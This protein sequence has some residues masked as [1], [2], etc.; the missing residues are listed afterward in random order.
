[1]C[2][3]AGFSDLT[4]SLLPESAL[5]GALARRMGQ[6]LLHRG[7]N[8]F[9][10]H[11]SAQSAMAH[12]R[13]AIM[14]PLHG[15]QP[16]TLPTDD[17]DV[18]LIYNGEIYNAPEL[19]RMLQSLG[20][21]FQTHCDTEVLLQC[22]LHFGIECGRMLNGI[23]AFV[24]D[25]TRKKQVFLCRDRFGVKPLFY[26]RSH[27][28]LVYA[29]EIKALFEYP[30]LNPVITREG[31][32]EVWGLGPARTPGCGVFDRIHEIKPGYC[33]L[34]DRSGFR[35]FPYYTL[36]CTPCEESYETV[37]ERLR[38][39]LEDTVKRQMQS[40]VPLCTFLSGGLDSSVVTALA[41]QFD[42]QLSTYSF[43]YQGNDTYFHP[44]AYQPDAD[45]PWA[46]KVS[47]LLH[48]DHHRLV[49]TSE[50]LLKTLHD[51][52]RARDLPGMADV[53]SSLLYFCSLVQKEHTVA[54]CG[55]CADEIFGGYPWFH[56]EEAL[57]ARV[58][59]WSPD[60]H[61]RASLLRPEVA[62][63][64]GLP[65]YV[66]ARYE[67]TV[68][69]V[70]A[71]P[72][73]SMTETRRREMSYLNLRWF[74]ATLLERKDRCSMACGLEVRVPYADH[75]II[76]LIYNTPW[77][78]KCHG[79]VRKSLLRD[80]AKGLLPEE[81]LQRKKSPYPKTHNPDYETMLRTRL[82]D[83][84][85]DPARPIHQLLS[86]KAVNDLLSETFDYGQPWFGQ[87]MAGPQLLAYLLQVNDWL[88]TYHIRIRL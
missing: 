9:G 67:E 29:S 13:L 81:V 32:C 73:E 48:T 7:P 34:L 88:E 69:E 31:L 70:P 46:E 45:E 11:V 14:D 37:T 74:M 23:F 66:V 19:R 72:G 65:E 84:L 30:G 6:T 39:L 77:D 51:S 10:C 4:T 16:F 87:L 24:V 5:W 78:Y 36:P 58:F 68:R 22:Y 38:A 2:G 85:R 63:V 49:C 53:D 12:A 57:L 62:E 79:G 35:T 40:D 1:M 43:D 54:L 75:R 47:H 21:T 18:T 33:G 52:L 15:S 44:T 8:D 20:V 3:I 27:D 59:P 26:A 76:E 64:L 61:R 86:P 82:Q 71:L 56:K 55:E 83:V 25:D 60:I 42:P 50:I 80:A 41:A 28:R 17:G